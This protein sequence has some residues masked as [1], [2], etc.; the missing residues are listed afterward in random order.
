MKS[1]LTVSYTLK[2]SSLCCTSYG[3]ECFDFKLCTSSFALNVTRLNPSRL[4]C[5]FCSRSSPGREK[6]P[7]NFWPHI[8]PRF[9][10]LV[11]AVGNNRKGRWAK[12]E[13]KHLSQVARC[14]S[15]SQIFSLVSPSCFALS[16]FVW[17]V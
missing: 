3:L 5:L 4:I 7:E 13:N 1:F 9:A 15:Y 2:A 10:P 16:L 6:T 14:G 12:K 8:G 17:F 11:Q